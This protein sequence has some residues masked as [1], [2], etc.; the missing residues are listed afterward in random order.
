MRVELGNKVVS[1]DGQDL[2]AIGYLIMDPDT[3]LVKR[4]VVEK[5]FLLK[6]DTEA[7][8]ESV[9]EVQGNGVRLDLRADQVGALPAFDETRYR[10]A[11]P[12][13]LALLGY[14]PGAVYWSGGMPAPGNAAAMGLYPAPVHRFNEETGQSLTGGPIPDRDEEAI[15]QET[16]ARN[17]VI[18]RGAEVTAANGE[19]LGTVD[20]ISFDSVT[21]KP[22][23]FLLRRGLLFSQDVEVPGDAIA[24]VADDVVYLS[25]NRTQIDDWEAHQPRALVS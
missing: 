6:Q 23:W 5:G 19:S 17:A 8:L 20:S 21:G 10:A 11:D 4:F 9:M 2:G 16:R 25:V 24:S 13:A 15:L 3:H 18:S 14:P 22:V 1:S 12:G 7:P